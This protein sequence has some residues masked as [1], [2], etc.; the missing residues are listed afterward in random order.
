MVE[1]KDFIVDTKERTAREAFGR[2]QTELGHGVG[3]RESKR[4]RVQMDQVSKHMAE[5]PGLFQ[6]EQLWQRK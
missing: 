1:E 3:L 4:G 5:M 2:L 6:N